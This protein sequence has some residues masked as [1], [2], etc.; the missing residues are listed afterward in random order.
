MT[1]DEV[2]A[3]VGGEGNLLSES[4]DKGTEF[5]KVMYY[6]TGEGDLGVNASFMF[7]GNKLQN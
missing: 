7:Q 5:Y 3:I 2:I 1:Y 4:R 6:Y